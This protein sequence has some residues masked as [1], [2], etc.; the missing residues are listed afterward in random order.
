MD[1]PI[2]EAGYQNEKTPSDHSGSER[3]KGYKTGLS[4]DRARRADNH[5]ANQRNSNGNAGE[6]AI[7]DKILKVDQSAPAAFN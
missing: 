7:D 6:K 4:S 2:G 1:H 5:L 3:V